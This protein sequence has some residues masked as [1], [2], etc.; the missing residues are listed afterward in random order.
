MLSFVVAVNALFTALLVISYPFLL[1]AAVI[2]HLFM[3]YRLKVSGRRTTNLK[4]LILRVFL[5]SKTSSFTFSGLVNFWQHFGSY[6]TVADPSF[7]KISWKK[8]FNYYFP[9]YILLI[10][11]IFTQLTDDKGLEE[12]QSIFGGFILLLIIAA[13]VFIVLSNNSLRRKFVSSGELL[14]KR[15]QHLDRWPTQYNNTFKEFPVMCYDN[16][17]KQAVSELVGT[18]NVIQMDLRGFSEAN[19]GCEY[20]MGFILDH[21]PV[22]RI[23]FLAYNDAVPLIKKVILERW[24]MLA[25]TSPNL[26]PQSPEAV[27]YITTK[28]DNKD[29]QCI[30]DVL[31]EKALKKEM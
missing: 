10:F 19:K 13:I 14:K 23:L 17:W 22:E 1:I 30:I 16:T 12:L 2:F 21:V 8:K 6:F 31:L 5:I 27:L 28:Q 11:L 24:K 9:I 15:L 7:Y 3:L 18:A 25:E 4:L 26:Q 20:E 29:I